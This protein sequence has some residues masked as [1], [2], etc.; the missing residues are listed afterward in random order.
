MNRVRSLQL[1]GCLLAI[2]GC[3]NQ[4]AD[5]VLGIGAS[6]VLTGQVFFDVNGTRALDTG[7]TTW[8]DTG[9]LVVVAATRDTVHGTSTDDAGSFEILALPVGTYSVVLDPS[10]LAD[11]VL[12]VGIDNRAVQVT[13]D[14]TISVELA[15]SYLAA[16]RIEDARSEAAETKLFVTG[17]ALNARATFN[18]STVHLAD[19]SGAIL[20]TGVLTTGILEGDSVRLLGTLT[21]RDG[22]P[23]L[24]NVQSFALGRG[25]IPDPPE[26]S[27]A[28]AVTAD[29][30]RLDA[31]LVSLTGAAIADTATSDD[32]VLLTVDDGSGSF[33]VLLDG[34]G[35]FTRAALVPGAVI[36]ARGLLIPRGVGSWRM[37]PRS[38][39]DIDVVVAPVTT[40]DVRGLPLGD[41][42]FVTGFALSAPNLFGDQTIHAA[43][44]AGAVRATDIT[45]SGIAAGDSIRLSG[46]VATSLGQRTL[47]NATVT[48]LGGLL[49]QDPTTATTAFAARAME[50]SLDAALVSV[51]DARI[52][53][54][55]T[56]GGDLVVTVNDGSG[57]LD[58][59]L[60]ADITFDRAPYRPGAVIEATGLLVP[61]GTGRWR[62]KP[63]S[64]DDLD[65]TVPVVTIAEARVMPAGEP[66][67]IIGLALNRLSTFG[68]LSVH[69]VDATGSIRGTNVDTTL[70][71]VGDSLQ[72]RGTLSVE[73]EQ[74]TLDMISPFLIT[75]E[76]N[77]TP[78]QPTVLTTAQAR[79]A[80][81]GTQD[82]GLVQVT[83]ATIASDTLTSSD[84]DF[85]F[86][87]DDASGPLTVILDVD[88]GISTTSIVPGNSITLIGV[89]LPIGTGTWQLKPRSNGDLQ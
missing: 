18:D 10:T 67:V 83:A 71:F 53:D 41:K 7:D 79:T 16:R 1:W 87:V 37:R 29:G 88:T 72:F 56:S 39:V 85:S 77:L 61:T 35:D 8:A 58:V 23:V 66:A 84:G 64:E 21:V 69:L 9:V 14:D 75:H 70:I 20:A 48:A 49:T 25:N 24:D 62:L 50:G 6:G 60:D 57:P 15:V 89:L 80:S 52:V 59:V 76:T 5:R 19:E 74:R 68:D 34:D 2:A 13:P 47:S 38:S 31:R 17:I 73:N 26:V 22:E 43:D 78:P 4:G 11:N 55:A 27:S 54:T 40:A 46:T 86:T 82:A 12:L 28:T 44:A 36:D 81:G 33:E 42:V 65:V 45:S 63:R 51:T 30:G 32:D 3:Q